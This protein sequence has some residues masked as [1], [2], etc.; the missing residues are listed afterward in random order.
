VD[1]HVFE[2]LK[3]MSEIKFLFREKENAVDFASGS[4]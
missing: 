3:T 2:E 4:K 1:P